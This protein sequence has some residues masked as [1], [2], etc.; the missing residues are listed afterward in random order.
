MPG[1]EVWREHPRDVAR[2]TTAGDV[3]DA[4]QVVPGLDERGAQAEHRSG[5]DPG[6]REEHLAERG[7]GM[8]RLGPD[9]AGRRVR[10]QAAMELLL[11]RPQQVQVPLGDERA[12][13]REAVRVEAVRGQADDRVAGSGRR[14]IDHPVALDDADAAAGHVER[15]RFHQTGMLGGFA[16]DERTAG[17]AT[18][19]GDAT[20]ELGG[21]RRVEPA[22]REVVQEE[23]RFGPAADNVVGT[24]RDQVDA[25][26]VVAPERGRDRR[27]RADPVGRRDE[28]RLAESGRNRHRAGKP[29]DTTKHLRPAGALDGRPHQLDRAIA[30]VDVDPGG[31]VGRAASG[32]VTS[33]RAGTGFLAC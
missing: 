10:P 32:S 33:F 12:D 20:D 7:E 21:S 8:L 25:D 13:E 28:D 2:E 17:L 19:G 26:R 31:R 24:H 15:G 16:T 29:A 30:R 22:D 5:V 3:G 6:G 18:S 23:E 14:A 11:V 27:L 1:A 4:V 9:R